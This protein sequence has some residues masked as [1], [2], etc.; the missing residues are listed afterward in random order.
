MDHSIRPIAA[1]TVSTASSKRVYQH[2]LA[3]KCALS[4]AENSKVSELSLFELINVVNAR[5]KETNGLEFVDKHSLFELFINVDNEL[6]S[7]KDAL[8][9]ALFTPSGIEHAINPL[10]NGLDDDEHVHTS[11]IT[12]AEWEAVRS[13]HAEVYSDE[14]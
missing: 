12:M 14:E 3:V 4:L 2:S 1:A 5:I 10:G 6:Q 9:D 11:E 8:E 7:R 13:I